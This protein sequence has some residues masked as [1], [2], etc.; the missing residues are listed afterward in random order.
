MLYKKERT[1]VEFNELIM[2][3]N[4]AVVREIKIYQGFKK[5][6]YEKILKVILAEKSSFS[7]P[8]KDLVLEIA[9]R[10]GAP[11]EVLIEEGNIIFCMRERLKNELKK[12]E[13]YKKFAEY[14]ED[15]VDNPTEKAGKKKKTRSEQLGIDPSK[16]L[17]AK[18]KFENQVTKIIKDATALI[19]Q[20]ASHIKWEDLKFELRIKPQIPY[21][22]K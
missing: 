15:K 10:T 22:I 5:I 1:F 7:I 12:N 3:I 18:N 6:S 11:N 21:L 20:Q 9:F 8:E 13:K 17:T 2:S 19:R 14:L 16:N 4:T